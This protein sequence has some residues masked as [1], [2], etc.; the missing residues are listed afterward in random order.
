MPFIGGF[1]DPLKIVSSQSVFHSEQIM[2]TK[3]Q[4]Y[5]Y[6]LVHHYFLFSGQDILQFSN[7]VSKAGCENKV[8]V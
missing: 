3:E 6:A 1:H 7:L 8:I 2:S 4:Q 5:I